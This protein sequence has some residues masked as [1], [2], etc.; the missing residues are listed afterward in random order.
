MNLC[1][2]VTF[3]VFESKFYDRLLSKK[4]IKRLSA[5]LIWT[6][7]YSVIKGSLNSSNC[8][9]GWLSVREY[10]QLG[11]TFLNGAEKRYVYYCFMQYENWKSKVNAFDLM[12]VVNHVW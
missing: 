10:L 5:N 4:M 3:D 1:F 2:E 12:D 6:E 11:T 7:I 9:Y 8:Y